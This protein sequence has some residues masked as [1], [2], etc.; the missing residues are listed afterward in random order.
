MGGVDQLDCYPNNLRPCIG[1]KKWYWMQL[2]NLVHLLQTAAFRLYNHLHPEKKVSQLDF[3]R[4][5]V[6]QYIRFHR[7]KERLNVSQPKLVS[8]DSNGHFLEPHTQGRCKF[9][10]KNCRLICNVCLHAQC[11]PLYHTDWL[12]T[13]KIIC[14]K[15][16]CIV[17]SMF[18][19]IALLVHFHVSNVLYLFCQFAF[20]TTHFST[21]FLV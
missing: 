3:L 8:R 10:K 20:Y 13:K 4:K 1:G 21:Y 14:H 17:I 6:H 7:R 16:D 12:N 11:F 19:T 18:R 15:K 5:L 2:I 9:C